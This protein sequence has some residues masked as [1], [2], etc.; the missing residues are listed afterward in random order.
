MMSRKLALI[1]G[2]SEY[3][4]PTLARL[5]A[6]RADVTALD[7]VLKHPE[8]GSFD[9]VT[10]L[11]DQPESVVRRAIARFFAEKSRDDLL[12]LYFSGHGVLDDQGQLY[13]AMKDT[14]HNLLSATAIPAALITREMDLSHPRRQILILDC[15]HSGAFARGAKGVVG[16]RVGTAAAFEGNGYGRVV[17]TA[18]DSTQY[19]WEGD[20]ILG[21]A[22][23]SMFTHYLIEGLQTGQADAD[24]DGQ[25]TL[26]E[27]YTYVYERMLSTM[28]RQTPGKWSYK[29]QGDIILAKNPRPIVKPAALPPE[30]QSALESPFSG[31]REGAVRE[32]DHLLR[33]TNTRLALTVYEVLVRLKDDDSR[34]VAAAATEILIAHGKRHPAQAEHTGAGKTAEGTFANKPHEELSEHLPRQIV[35]HGD[36][37]RTGM[38]N[39]PRANPVT[40]ATVPIIGASSIENKPEAYYPELEN[41]QGLLPRAIILFVSM[42]LFV[43]FLFALR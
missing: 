31:V 15:C 43:L 35:K 40:S 21:Q 38:V 42:L 13:L 28:P 30:L 9:D 18:T 17:L 36:V 16:A 5:V 11:I 25:I 39:K 34:R 6:P 33:S 8:V 24:D 14:E 4:D 37:N 2:S 41:F 26:D 12:L 3:E 1:I 19:A 27:L 7:S 23:N 22:E 20:R 32:L 10:V 29:Q